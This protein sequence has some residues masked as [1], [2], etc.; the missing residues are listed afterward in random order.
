MNFNSNMA[1]IPV[2]G[3]QNRG[4]RC[5]LDLNSHL[6]YVDTLVSAGII[7]ENTGKSIKHRIDRKSVV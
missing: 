4:H 2:Q 6:I 7:D 5:N 1:G 3:A